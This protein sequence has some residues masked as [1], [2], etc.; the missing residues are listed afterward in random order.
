[1]TN[2]IT[3]PISAQGRL[4]RQ[5]PITFHFFAFALHPGACATDNRI[6][7]TMMMTLKRPGD[8]GGPPRPPA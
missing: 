7:T 1:M 6:A 5:E 8:I 2:A 3:T 4:L